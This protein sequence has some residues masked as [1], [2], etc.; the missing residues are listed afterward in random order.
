[1]SNV[2]TRFNIFVCVYRLVSSIHAIMATAAGVVVVSAC[3]DN[4]IYDR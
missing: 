1:M 3:R 2:T 4:V